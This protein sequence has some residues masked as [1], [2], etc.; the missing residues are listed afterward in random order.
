MALL[1][2][3]AVL[4]L[5]V[6]SVIDAATDTV[7]ETIPLP[8]VSAPLYILFSSILGIVVSPDGSEVYVSFASGTQYGFL[9]GGVL[10]ISTETSAVVGGIS[11]SPDGGPGALFPGVA[12]SPDGGKVYVPF[13]GGVDTPYFGFGPQLAEIDTTSG[14]LTVRILV[15]NYPESSAGGL[16]ITPDGSKLMSSLQIM[17]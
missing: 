9:D 1:T 7:I 5:T 8:V 10:V 3:S 4:L 15:G 2:H 12:V 6:I 17:N 16:A 11:I 13:L 14:T